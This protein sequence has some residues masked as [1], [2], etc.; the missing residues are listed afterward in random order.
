MYTCANVIIIKG[1]PS[2]R[3]A[4]AHATRPF[5]VVWVWPVRLQTD[6]DSLCHVALLHVSIYTRTLHNTC[7]KGNKYT[8][9]SL[10]T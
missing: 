5:L 6:E 1:L 3:G 4:L 10:I 9:R 2:E 7:G 8:I